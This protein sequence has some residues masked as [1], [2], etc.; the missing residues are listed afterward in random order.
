MIQLREDGRNL[1]LSESV[2]QSVVDCLR[3]YSQPRRSVP[4]DRDIRLEPIVQ[5]VGCHVAQRRQSLQLGHQLRSP[6]R[7]FLR[8]RIFNR[9]LKLR[10]AHAVFHRKILHRL[11]VESNAVDLR[12]FRLQPPN[13]R[14][15]VVGAFIS[16]LQIDLNPAFVRRGVRAIYSDE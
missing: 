1:A 7:Q 11:H 14:R 16:R 9:I 13:N 2:V 5:L 4:V 3:E 8:V 12:Q 6:L 15:S 10:A